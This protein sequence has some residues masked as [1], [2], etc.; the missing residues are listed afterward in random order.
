MLELEEEELL[1]LEEELLLIEEEEDEEDVELRIQPLCSF[2]RRS[3]TAL[4]RARGVI[5]F[6]I[7]SI[8]DSFFSA[9]CF[10]RRL[11]RHRAFSRPFLLPQATMRSC[12]RVLL[13]T[14]SALSARFIASARR[15]VTRASPVLSKHGRVSMLEEET[16]EEDDDVDVPVVSVSANAGSAVRAIERPMS[17]DRDFFM[18]IWGREEEL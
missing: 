8:W 14:F 16:D 13:R 3:F 10:N 9:C 18:E 6:C 11:R 2:A 15:H 4:R 5:F 1:E 12:A 17:A 7:F